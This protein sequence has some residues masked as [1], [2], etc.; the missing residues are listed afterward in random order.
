MAHLIEAIEIKRQTFFEFEDDPYVCLDAEV[1]KPTACWALGRAGGLRW[2][3]PRHQTM[4]AI[5]G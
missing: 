1:S 3:R 2:F 5:R 4:V